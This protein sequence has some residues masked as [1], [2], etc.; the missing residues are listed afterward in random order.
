MSLGWRK[1]G[2]DM[3]MQFHGELLTV[4]PAES[5]ALLDGHLAN[6]NQRQDPSEKT[7]RGWDERQPWGPSCAAGTGGLSCGQPAG[8]WEPLP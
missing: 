2:K 3:S 5:R 8:E 1:R 4:M 6:R 7:K